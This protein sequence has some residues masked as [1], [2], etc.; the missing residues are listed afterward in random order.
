VAA[1][2]INLIVASFVVFGSWGNV[3]R[4]QTISSTRDGAYTSEQA[5]QGKTLYSKQCAICHG[6]ALEGM[7]QNPPLAGDDFINNWDGQTLA[8]L[9]AKI[10][11]TMPATSPGSLTP[12][13]TTQLLAYIL[14]ANQFPAGKTAIPDDPSKLKAIRIDKPQQKP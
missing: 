11:T 4:T 3:L 5:S 2:I 7:G 14:S 10:Q 13:E 6:T 1:K 8:D 9:D 12:A